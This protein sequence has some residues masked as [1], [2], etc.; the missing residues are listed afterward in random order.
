M[1]YWLFKQEPSTYNYAQLEKDGRTVWDGVA[2][3]L[4]LKHL[5]SVKKGDRAIFYHTGDE[6]QAVGIIDIVSDPYPDPKEKDESL[7]VVDVKP[8]G[9]LKKPVALEKIKSDPAFAQWELVRVSRLSVM[10]V[11]KKLWE[12]IMKMSG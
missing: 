2:N 3:N 5:R 10:P 6:K 1:A 11:P 12:R 4:A 8:A 9:R 7:V